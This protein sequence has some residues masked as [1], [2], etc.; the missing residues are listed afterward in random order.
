MIKQIIFHVFIRYSRLWIN[1]FII[2]KIIVKSSRQ[3][4]STSI[5]YS[6]I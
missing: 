1:Y 2:I 4:F 6:K 5:K 3:Y